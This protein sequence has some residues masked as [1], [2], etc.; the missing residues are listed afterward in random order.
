MQN[1]P[2]FSYDPWAHCDITILAVQVTSLEV[3]YHNA[4]EVE[5]QSRA[6]AVPKRQLQKP[7]CGFVTECASQNKGVSKVH[8]GCFPRNIYTEGAFVRKV[9]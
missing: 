8:L 6:A 7:F 9:A 1:Y 2:Q 4:W 5:D 3:I